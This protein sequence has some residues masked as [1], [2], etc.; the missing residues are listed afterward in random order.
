MFDSEELT[1]I[2]SMIGFG[3]LLTL[4][5]GFLTFVGFLS[6][7]MWLGIA[8]GAGGLI[9][10]IVGVYKGVGMGI[11]DDSSQPLVRHTNAQIMNCLVY[12]KGNEQVF[13][14]DLFDPE[15]LQYIVQILHSDGR[16]KEY[17]SGPM[18]FD[19]LGEGMKGTLILQGRTVVGFERSMTQ[20]GG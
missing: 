20:N 19:T 9:L 2:V 10:L 6:G 15:E 5:G 16:R 13:D 12:T 8:L 18:T 14:R 17:Q 1:P 3:V 11:R 7:M 4:V